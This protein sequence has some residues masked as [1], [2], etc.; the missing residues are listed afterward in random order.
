MKQTTLPRRR[1]SGRQASFLIA[2]ALLAVLGCR[3]EVRAQWT[4]PDANN[5]INNTNTGNVG[6]GNAA[7]K[8]KI[9]LSTPASA[10]QLRFGSDANDSGG[11]LVSTS[12][13]QAMMSGGASWNGSNWVAR[14]SSFSAVNASDGA[15]I[16]LTGTGLTT[17]GVF[18]P[19]ERMRVT[20]TG[21]VGIGTA[22]PASILHLG[23]ND[24]STFAAATLGGGN[25]RIILQNDASANNAFGDISFRTLDSGGNG[26]TAVRLTGIFTNHAL[27]SVSGDL[28]VT[29]MN[30]STRSEVARFTGLGNVGI[31][32]ATPNAL[33][34]LD[35]AGSMNASGGL[36]IAGVCKTNWSQVGGVSQWTTGGSN[37][38][39]NTGNVGVGTDA[40]DALLSVRKDQA[41]GTE[42]RVSNSNAAGFSGLYLN[43]G[44]AQSAGGFVQ[45]NNTTGVNNLFVG[46]GGSNPLHLG[47]NNSVR[48]TVVPATGN[49]GVGTTSPSHKFVVSGGGF[50]ANA[51]VTDS[52]TSSTGLDIAN[53]SAGSKTWRLQSVG[54]GVAGR[55]GNFELWEM[56]GVMSALTI[57]PSG[58]VGIGTLSPLYSLDI[59]GGI[60]GLRA[61]AATTNA[62]DIVAT[63]ENASGVQ[64]VIRGNGVFGIGTATPNA[65]YKLDVAGSINASGGLCIAGTCKASWSEVGGSSQWTTGGSNVYFN[66]GNVGVGAGATAPVVKLA[67]GGN[68]VNVYATDA[69]FDNNL[70]AQGNET[71]AQGGRG[72]LRVG[73]AWGYM[74][75]YTE[76]SSS[77]AANDLLLG[78]GS[79]TVR[80]GPGG[81]IVQNLSVPNG[82]INVTGTTGNITASGTITGGNIQAKYQD[83]AEWVPSTQELAAGTVVVLDTGRNNHVIASSESYD[84]RVAGVVS[85]QPGL[86]LGESGTGK[87]M[88]ATTG[89]VKVRVDATRAPVRIGDLLV[90]SGAEG[91]A[92]K[93]VPFDMGG[94]AIHRPGTIIGK[95]LEPLEK[96]VGE[97]LVL[98]SLQ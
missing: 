35:V 37:I 32:T 2:L 73:T 4:T 80:V 94:T 26:Q 22:S 71:L 53:T 98:L 18:T 36:C 82:D 64:A 34:K 40:P 17:G 91:M 48:L 33:Y 49:V 41:A 60:N 50:G 21:Y 58:L 88:V 38:Y 23:G 62:A 84:T 93:S 30:A 6:V 59:N 3:G 96:G 13:S 5:N 51:L 90:T 61:K 65:L 89:R 55:V 7:P 9:D 86:I 14:S 20:A 52:N 72:R 83:V 1:P 45:W 24:A 12:S 29:T 92:M 87:V 76:S 69:W 95:A 54:G 57:K 42:I 56:S 66:T 27:G 44:F 75:L 10:T 78:S 68:G 85:A 43:S 31:G 63:F 70:H 67:V 25:S 15:L 16:F 11:Y 19:A 47:T 46:T 74:G 8:Y 39:F 81:G 97:I 77:G 28:A 79:G